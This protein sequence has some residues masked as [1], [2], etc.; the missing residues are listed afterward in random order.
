MK[1]K[2]I[3]HLIVFTFLALTGCASGPKTN[4][5]VTFEGIEQMP[6]KTEVHQACSLLDQGEAEQAQA[7]FQMLLLKYENIEPQYRCGLL[8]NVAMASI[9]VGDQTR[10]VEYAQQLENLAIHLSPIPRN[11]QI[12]LALLDAMGQRTKT[13]KLWITETVDYAVKTATLNP[14]GQ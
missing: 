3:T 13:D 8:T 2:L 12:V 1:N 9:Q 4:K 11:S 10:F 14:G 6:L 7:A 5:G